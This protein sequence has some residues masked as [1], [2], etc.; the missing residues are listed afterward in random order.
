MHRYVRTTIA[1]AL[2]VMTVTACTDVTTEPRSTVSSANA[3]NDAGS[4]RAFL[5]KLY[6]GLA[7]TGQEGPAGAADIEGI[8][9]GFSQYVR[10]L[11]Q[12]QQ[13]PTD[14]VVIGW[15]DDGLPE[16]NTHQW[17]SSNPF[18]TALYYRI[19]F[20]IALSNEFL[21]E[22]T[23]ARLTSRGVSDQL[24]ADIQQYRAEARFL[25]A[26]S[27]W[28]GI[29]LFANIPLVRETD[30]FGVQAPPQSTR[31]ETFN[32]L[33]TEVNEVR[34]LLPAPGQAQYG[35]ADQGAA[36]MLLAKLYLN[37]E[38]YGTGAQWAQV[39]AETQAIIGSNAYQLPSNYH[40]N[41]LANNHTSPEIIFAVPF[42]GERTRTWGGTTFLAHAAVGGNMDAS[43]YG[44]DGGWWGMRVTPQFVALFGGAG[45][46]DRRSNV[47]FTQGHTLQINNLG[48]FF[49]GYPAP[50]YRNVTSNGTPGS[51]PT[52][53][54]VD[55]PMF[56]LADAYL[57][58]AEAVLRGGGGTPQQALTYVNLLRT[59]AYGDNS[60]HI[61]QGQL[62]LDFIIDE[63]ARELWWEGHRRTDLIRFNRF[64][65]NGVWAWKGN[66]AQGQTTPAFRNLYPIP[67]SE[68]LA[69]PNLT[70]NTGY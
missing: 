34:P 33:V 31:A 49:H 48:D 47:F 58:Y 17:S 20:Q 36:R 52:F 56:R 8:D 50:K 37:S 1:A 12:L 69:N 21:R 66:T 35:R 27:Y 40:L 9:E 38:Q 39:I 10:G 19:F 4:Y 63:R 62:T 41:F 23:E 68:M 14:E 55:Y 51:N 67:A 57:M 53:P 18:V 64:S 70:Q 11:W 15:G 61:T 65:T 7:V 29:D 3:F 28:H 46:P 24:R 25:R 42:D 45:G 32:W 44:L 54:D 60:G 16:L 22:T 43:A 2:V 6:A 30:Q 5:A 13:L 59:R 26:L